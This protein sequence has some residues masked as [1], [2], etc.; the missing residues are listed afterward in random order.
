MGIMSPC[1]GCEDRSAECHATCKRYA[2][3]RAQCD[4]NIKKRLQSS[5]I[6]IN[7]RIVKMRREQALREKRGRK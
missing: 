1:K 3:Y 7:P 4:E 2:E 6:S 5:S